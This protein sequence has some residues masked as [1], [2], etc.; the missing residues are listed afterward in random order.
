MTNKLPRARR[1]ATQNDLVLLTGLLLIPP[2]LVWSSPSHVLPH[3]SLDELLHE[4]RA[5]APVS[6]SK[7]N[8]QVPHHLASHE[9]SARNDTSTQPQQPRRRNRGGRALSEM[10]ERAVKYTADKTSWSKLPQPPRPLDPSSDNYGY[11]APGPLRASIVEPS[12]AGDPFPYH[13]ALPP[14]P[15]QALRWTAERAEQLPAYTTAHP[16]SRSNYQPPSSWL[17]ARSPT[18]PSFSPGKANL[19]RSLI[20]LLQGSPRQCL[21]ELQEEAEDDDDSG[22]LAWDL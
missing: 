19:L 16:W 18:V 4:P 1:V 10:A 8:K 15:T 20:S 2:L 21:E 3:L 14:R 5:S 12:H 17:R 6:R 22:W 13:L 11:L 9:T 7:D